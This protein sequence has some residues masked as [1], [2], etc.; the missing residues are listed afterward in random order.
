MKPADTL[1]EPGSRMRNP[2]ISSIFHETQLAEAKGTGIGTM[3]RLMKEAKL[4]PP[5]F[6]S[7][8][9]RNIFTT[10]ILFHHF[11]PEEDLKWLASLPVANLTY[12]QKIAFIFLREVG[13]IDNLTYRQLSGVTAKETSKELKRLEKLNLIEAKG[14]GRKTYYIPTERLNALCGNSVGSPQGKVTTSQGKVITFG[15]DIRRKLLSLGKRSKKSELENVIIDMCGVAPLS[16]EEIANYT[17][18][19]I[20]YIRIKILPGLLRDKRIKYTFPEMINHPN[21]KYSAQ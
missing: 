3:R 10:R 8:T 1:G 19:T 5:T 6:E 2:N 21:Q 7:D 14:Q 12:A 9:S 18:R 17:N 13:A 16:I 15:E 4:M 11:L 20:S